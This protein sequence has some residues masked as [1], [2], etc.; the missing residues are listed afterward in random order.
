METNLCPLRLNCAS[1]G[2]FPSKPERTMLNPET[3]PFVPTPPATDQ[4]AINSTANPSPDSIPVN[5]SRNPGR[6]ANTV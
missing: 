4:Q 2:M 6:D 5:R 1:S 3:T